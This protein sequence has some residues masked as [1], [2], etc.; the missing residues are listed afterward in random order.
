MALRFRSKHI[1]LIG[2]LLLLFTLQ[3]HGQD[4]SVLSSG[5][6][7]KMEFAQE[8][9]YKIDR[10]LLSNMGF[11]VA[12]LDPRNL[13]IYGNNGGM[14]PQ[15][16]SIERAND[17]TENAISVIGEADGVFNNEDYLLFYV[18]RVDALNF[19]K[20]D[21]K[22]SVTKNL[23]AEKLSYFLT[24]KEDKGIRMNELADLGPDNPLVTFY[25]KIIAHELDDVNILGSGREWFGESFGIENKI[26][27]DFQ[28]LN[29]TANQPIN[30]SI[31]LMAQ[32]FGSTSANIRLNNQTLG[33]INLESIPN[34]RYGIKGAASTGDF[35]INSSSLSVLNSLSLE[36]T[37]DKRGVNN[38]LAYLNYFLLDI[39]S[40]LQFDS[41]A[42]IFRSTSALDNGIS[43]FKIN[44]ANAN[45]LVWDITRPLTPSLQNKVLN[46]STLSFGAFS[47][48]LQTYVAFD[49]SN[50]PAPDIF[51]SLPNQDL[52]GS[53][54]PDLVIV[55]AEEFLTEAH[56]LADFRRSA[57]QLNVLVATPQQIY[58]EFS[59]GRPDVTAI[60]DFM[61]YL[62]SKSDRFKYLLLF[63]KGSYDYKN[64][65]ENNTNFVPTYESRS[66]LH[67][68]TSYSSDDYFGFLDPEE[69]EWIEN[70][71]GD[72]ILDVGIGR[73]PS[74]SPAQAK[75]AVD[76]I[77]NYQNS[78]AGIGDWRRRIVFVADDGD[79][80]LH[81]R[82]ADRLATLV[83]TSYSAFNV[84]KIYLD[85]YEQLRSPNGESSPKAE[86]ALL[87]AVEQG[88]LIMN[89][90]GHGAETGWMQERILSLES[91]AN[92]K[93]STRL[94]LVVTATCEFGRNDDPMIVSGAEEL[95]FK[96]NGGA[97]GLI[98]TAR[99][100]FSS[101]NYTL[102]LALYGSILERPNGEFQRLGDIIQYSKN[103]ALNGANNRN[104][105]LLADPS[106]R[107][108]YPKNEIKITKINDKALDNEPDTLQAL[109]RVI[110]EGEI[111]NEQ[112]TVSS[113]N[114][115]LDF[116]LFDKRSS[117][118]T[119]G[120]ESVPFE[121]L[122]RDSQLFNGKASI[123]NGLFKIEF[124]VPKNINYQF[125]AGKI[126]MYA[127]KTDNIQ[128]AMGAKI[129]FVLGGTS[130]AVINDTQPPSIGA[131][132]NDTTNVSKIVVKKDA[133]L[134]LKVFDESGINIS[135][136]GI[137]QNLS[138]TLNDSITYN[139]NG[140]YQA[141][142]DDF[143]KGEVNFP[144][145]GLPLG[146][147]TLDIK[148]W[149]NFNNVATSSI[150]FEVTSENST[151]IS[152]IN[153][154]P[155]PL[156]NNTTFSVSHNSAGEALEIIIEIINS[157]GEKVISLVSEIENS[158]NNQ[159]IAW[160]GTDQYGSKLGKGIYIYSV[161]LRAINSGKTHVKRQK[162][163]ISY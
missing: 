5:K 3:A 69:G 124:V 28:D 54:V 80:N 105:I 55:S 147:N 35:S 25:N 76:K 128:D 27:F 29:I 157:K 151:L 12:N 113:F 71:S 4:N 145:R 58:N 137:G 7:V 133:T 96:E 155:N 107:L 136:S 140:F 53:A 148:A 32:A 114:G 143:R 79:N 131:F 16:L 149:D 112:Q 13:A 130:K 20:T 72:H 98:T 162:L 123:K 37:F 152:E 33:G 119:L 19:D 117:R 103:N 110:V 67:P 31:G 97:I 73:I 15:A 68:L 22:F 14:L 56:R 106:M 81:Q 43:T 30:V 77:I 154:Y 65:I 156:I 17:L 100:V 85:A 78:I 126:S 158:T 52:R 39:P 62:K 88:V 21:R 44:N 108:S 144:M 116:S 99:P 163:I 160:D 40:N 83:D 159:T 49:P 118:K 92:W 60:R 34:T 120:S 75:I 6:W 139:L 87:D 138:A 50:L 23:Y 86:K 94:P 8:G 18:D 102:N 122:E 134:L 9:V 135:E 82:D 1:S 84:R 59:S 127:F 2:A 41:K 146:T 89:F 61:A 90:T 57:D 38:A 70:S 51:I 24:L 63:G 91:I 161:F 10:T 125:G 93:N 74:T 64:R 132:I 46:G 42:L 26:N 95:I 47:D 115:E 109:Q 142:K 141:V 48:E 104:F 45:V 101:S 121:Y 129:D 36:M 153:S 150:Q 111:V 11:D 66:S